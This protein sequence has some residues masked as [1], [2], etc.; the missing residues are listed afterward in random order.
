MRQGLFLSRIAAT[1]DPRAFER[2]QTINCGI[3]YD[4][5]LSGWWIERGSTAHS[6]ANILGLRL[7]DPN[8]SWTKK[9]NPNLNKTV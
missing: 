4:V 8:T 7:H 2:L 6:L 3:D 9:P 1:E 5:N